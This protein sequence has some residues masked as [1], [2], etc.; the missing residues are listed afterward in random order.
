MPE[1]YPCQQAEQAA[2][3][4]KWSL[5]IEPCLVST[6]D[7]KSAGTSV[8]V[9]SFI[10]MSEPSVVTASKQL[11][12]KGHFCMKR[13]AAMGKGGVHVGTPYMFSMAG[14]GGI[15]AE[16][17]LDLLDSMAFTLSGL[18]GPWILGGD[19]NCTPDELTATGWLQKVGGVILAPPLFCRSRVAT[20]VLL[21]TT[22]LSHPC[23]SNRSD[24]IRRR[25]KKRLTHHAARALR[26]TRRETLHPSVTHA[27]YPSYGLFVARSRKQP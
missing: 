20:S 12:A 24:Q 2:R 9:R 17:N 21:D 1:G 5:A 6:L 10:G 14:K 8:A 11:H 16:C 7:G 3:N 4:T 13:V 19:W 15:Q 26:D 18:V 22:T 27:I 23:G 25:T